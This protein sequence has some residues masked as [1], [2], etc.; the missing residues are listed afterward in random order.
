[1]SAP[2]AEVVPAKFTAGDTQK[3][4]QSFAD[5]PASD[6]WTLTYTL[7]KTGTYITFDASAS[8]D[9]YLVNVAKATTAA[10]S[11]SNTRTLSQSL[12]VLLI[13]ANFGK[14]VR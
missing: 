7:V 14:G 4:K 8:G 13:Y 9:E 12:I 5:Y 3:F 6:G 10:S 2:I 1:M 11:N